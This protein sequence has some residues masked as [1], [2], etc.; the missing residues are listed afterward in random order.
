VVDRLLRRILT[1]LDAGIDACIENRRTVATVLLPGTTGFLLLFLLFSGA[2]GAVLTAGVFLFA[3]EGAAAIGIALLY[4]RYD[5]DHKAQRLEV[6]DTIEAFITGSDVLTDWEEFLSTPQRD[7]ELEAIRLR[8]AGLAREFPP[9]AP[10]EYCDPRGLEAL[11]PYI[12]SLRAGIATKLYLELRQWWSRRD[13]RRESR[14]VRKAQRLARRE[15]RRTERG[16]AEAAPRDPLAPPVEPPAPPAPLQ[17]PVPTGVQVRAAGGSA[18]LGTPSRAQAGAGSDAWIRSPFTGPAPSTGQGRG[19]A[20]DQVASPSPGDSHGIAAPIPGPLLAQGQDHVAEPP[21]PAPFQV[22]GREGAAPGVPPT[23]QGHTGQDAAPAESSP[24][25]PPGGR[26]QVGGAESWIPPTPRGGHGQAG[27]A[28]VPIP[29]ATVGDTGAHAGAPARSPSEDRWPGPRPTMQSAEEPA[30]QHAGGPGGKAGRGR[31]SEAQAI[32]LAIRQGFSAR[33]FDRM[34]GDLAWQQGRSVSPEDVIKALVA[35]RKKHRKDGKGSKG[36]AARMSPRRAQSVTTH[37]RRP[38]LRT[39][40]VQAAFVLAAIG[41]LP[42]LAFRVTNGEPVLLEGEVRDPGID[43]TANILHLFRAQF[44]QL[45]G[46]RG[47]SLVDGPRIFMSEED[48]ARCWSDP[49]M[50][51]DDRNGYTVRIAA[52]ARPL[53]LGGYEVVRVRRVER[54]ATPQMEAATP[55]YSGR[56][57]WQNASRRNLPPKGFYR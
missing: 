12:A 29:S 15:G 32:S 2:W 8:C 5:E 31:M 30:E 50:G 54:V 7:E 19:A 41:G 55:G 33:D 23:V 11:L 46:N 36:R 14:G 49:T 10:G 48:Y 35:E 21:I 34:Q 3:L 39:G 13:Q 22:Q 52:E 6:A 17:P 27:G 43:P 40:R 20:G 44:E 47:V 4:F 57:S 51:R 56:D 38:R 28:G 16:R 53:L 26:A 1:R 24:E 37:E 9:V 42:F 45:F 25:Q 18:P